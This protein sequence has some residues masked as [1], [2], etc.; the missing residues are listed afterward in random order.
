MNIYEYLHIRMYMN[1]YEYRG[2]VRGVEE[3]GGQ[4]AVKDLF[5]FH[6]G[7]YICE[8]ILIYLRP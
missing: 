8:F 5:Y 4:T 3:G 6:T 1:I 7:S 2:R